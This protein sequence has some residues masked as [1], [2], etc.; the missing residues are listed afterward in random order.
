MSVSL[1]SA[2]VSQPVLV[3]VA[4]CWYVG[5]ILAGAGNFCFCMLAFPIYSLLLSLTSVLLCS[6][7]LF[8][9]QRNGRYLGRDALVTPRR[10]CL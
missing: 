9:V 10:A 4:V 1:V 8:T 3:C 6:T 7:I 2:L 5:S